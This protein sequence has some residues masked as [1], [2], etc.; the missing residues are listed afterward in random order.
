VDFFDIVTSR[1]SIRRYKSDPPERTVLEKIVAAGQEAPSGCN[2]QGK[3]FIV[4]DD[5][6]LLEQMRDVSPAMETA[7][8]AIVLAIEPTETRF[9][10]FWVQDASAAMENMLLAA[11]ALGLGG[12]WVEGA[13][14]RHE[15]RLRELLGVP[16]HLRVWSLT[17]IGTP[18]EAP[19]RPEKP[20]PTQVTHVNR[21]GQS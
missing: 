8:A 12:C 20:T 16:E 9:G 11:V 3:Q 21:F 7:P 1:R 17:P 6:D 4:V 5:A 10:E 2:V 13:A 19:D 15:D 14:R 18:D